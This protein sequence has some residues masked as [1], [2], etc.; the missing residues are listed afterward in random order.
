MREMGFN[1]VINIG[2]FADAQ[3]VLPLKVNK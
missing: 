1:S 2:T 3:N